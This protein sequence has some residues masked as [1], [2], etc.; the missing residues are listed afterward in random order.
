MTCC[1]RPL[2]FTGRPGGL[3]ATMTG[4][5]A[6]RKRLFATEPQQP[7][8]LASAGAGGTLGSAVPDIRQAVPAG[9][10]N[11]PPLFFGRVLPIVA[12]ARGIGSSDGSPTTG[13]GAADGEAEAVRWVDRPG[14]PERRGLP[15]RRHHLADRD[16]LATRPHDHQLHRQVPAL[17][18]GDQ[19]PEDGDL[20]EVPV[21]RIS[22]SDLRR[23]SAGS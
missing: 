16:T 22:G 18:T 14:C 9:R 7:D 11:W 21:R 4:Q 1:F 23:R 2:V 10:A 17:C 13:S 3:S 20:A 12:N 5:V 8:I 19:H 6:D 15:H